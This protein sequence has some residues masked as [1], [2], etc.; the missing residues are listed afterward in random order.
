M[1]LIM[2][3]RAL[4]PIAGG[5]VQDHSPRTVFGRPSPEV[6]RLQMICMEE[7][8]TFVRKAS[9]KVIANHLEVLNHSPTTRSQLHQALANSGL[10]SKGFI[11]GHGE[12]L[13]GDNPCGPW[14]LPC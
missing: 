8:V 10:L 5:K 2:M 3:L 1:G 9:G 7:L 4:N 12:T 6:L 13:I 14:S 11:P